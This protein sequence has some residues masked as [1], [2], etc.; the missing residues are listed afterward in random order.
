M[1]TTPDEIK[2]IEDEEFRIYPLT[3]QGELSTMIQLD[4]K[5][6]ALKEGLWPEKE[7]GIIVYEHAKARGWTQEG[8]TGFE[9][10]H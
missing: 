6:W 9:L 2:F 10:I 5:A 1:N 8:F 4:M 7:Y 3:A